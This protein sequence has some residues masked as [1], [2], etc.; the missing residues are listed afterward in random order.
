LFVSYNA[1]AE[2]SAYLPL[3]WPMPSHILDLN[4]EYRYLVN[5]KVD[6]SKPRTLQTALRYF[7]LPEV[8]AKEHWQKLILSG[9][10]F[11]ADQKRGILNYC[12]GDVDAAAEL[13]QVM[14]PK[15]PTDLR[16]ALLRGRYT[17]AVA[18]TERRGIPIDAET[19]GAM[20]EDRETIQLAL[21]QAVNRSV[22]PLYDEAGHFKFEAF[23][24][25]LEALGLAG[26]WKRTR[27]S[28]RLMID[29]ETLRR[30]AWHPAIERMRQARQAIQQLRKPS[31]EVI[32][33]RNY[34]SILP[35]KAQTSRNSTIGC[36]FQASRWLRGLV[37]PKPDIDLLYC[38]FEQE[39]FLIGGALAGDDAVLRLYE[40][41]DP[42]VSYGVRAGILP[43]GATKDTHPL[44][45]DLAKTMVLAVQFGM[46]PHGLA[47]RINVSLREAAELLKTHRQIFRRYWAWSDETVLRA[48]WSGWIESVYGW[49][50]TVG[51][52]IE[53]TAL[54]NFKIQSAGAEILRIAHLL[55]WEAGIEV[56]S[57]VHDAFLIQSRR[58]DL[59]DVKRETQRAME[60]ASAYVLNGHKLRT[61]I[62]TLAYPDRLLDKRG[63]AMWKLVQAIQNRLRIA[64]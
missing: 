59:E 16:R 42:Y 52:D 12:M 45:R 6:K 41:E 47:R 54:R 49:R 26:K 24:R 44:E 13:L 25:C 22:Y 9:G 15:L 51:N 31:F 33:G 50:L 5:G 53:D 58:A 48:R 7:G 63:Q 39:E 11:D 27:R 56:L 32:D 35:F 8:E 20:L 3:G 37:Q 14:A 18:D 38:D 1:P 10:P 61:E 40:A 30:F 29:D 55:L 4:I 43:P 62:L 60:K 2:L 36:I 21:A 19:W 57:P 28:G 64:T 17:I 46:T 34:F 23:A